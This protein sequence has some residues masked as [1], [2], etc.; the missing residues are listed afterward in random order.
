M[1]SDE[2]N[3][4]RDKERAIKEINILLKSEDEIVR[5][6][7]QD[8]KQTTQEHRIS[9]GY[10][11]QMVES[12]KDQARLTNAEQ[13]SLEALT[14][15]YQDIAKYEDE[16]VDALK[17]RQDQYKQ[18]TDIV[19][20][21]SSFEKISSAGLEQFK[22]QAI[23]NT[24][25]W[26]I[27]SK[28]A[29]VKQ[30]Q[31][32]ES[33]SARTPE[34]KTFDDTITRAKLIA[35]QQLAQQISQLQQDTDNENALNSAKFYEAKGNF[36][37]AAGER[38]KVSINE[39]V[40]TFTEALSKMQAYDASITDKQV[41]KSI[42]AFTERKK[43]AVDYFG[44]IAALQLAG[45]PAAAKQLSLEAQ[46]KEEGEK[47]VGEK[48]AG[49]IAPSAKKQKEEVDEY[50]TKKKGSTEYLDVKRKAAIESG[51]IPGAL[52]VGAAQMGKETVDAIKN[53]GTHFA[54]L[55]TSVMTMAGVAA[56][57]MKIVA[58][59]D[60]LRAEGATT[61]KIYTSM[62]VATKELTNSTIGSIK[63]AV[64]FRNILDYTSETG[65]KDIDFV[66]TMTIR[67]AGLEKFV[68]LVGQAY[69]QTA[70]SGR[71][72]L[73]TNKQ[74][75]GENIQ[76]IRDTALLG[77]VF[78]SSA[79]AGMQFA[80]DVFQNLRKSGQD[81]PNLY[82]RIANA[83]M[84]AGMGFS[85][86]Y[87]MI[88]QYLPTMYESGVGTSELVNTFGNFS[89]TLAKAGAPITFIQN[90]LSEMMKLT[91]TNFPQMIAETMAATGSTAT[92]ALAEI[93]T[94]LGSTG[95]G[96]MLSYRLQTERD[97][98]K[99]FGMEPKEG[100]FDLKS[101]L[102]LQ[103]QFGAS[104]QAILK[105]QD[106][107]ANFLGPE[108]GSATNKDLTDLTQQIATY[109]DLGLKTMIDQKT[110]LELIAD[111]IQNIVSLIAEYFV[112]L[113]FNTAELNTSRQAKS[114]ESQSLLSAQS[115][116]GTP[117]ANDKF[118]INSLTGMNF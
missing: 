111:G 27:K 40:Q 71:L 14:K 94:K 1:A 18:F 115:Q 109:D 75:H 85:E 81:I 58:A 11:K 46:Y 25:S 50:I 65:K 91:Q 77:Q 48:Y 113:G 44:A 22:K 53:I 12:L 54:T 19:A 3:L 76:S 83:A 47:L 117:V 97:I 41:K 99:K 32:I 8:L 93:T 37:K 26:N 103:Q 101:L 35:E 42:D 118:S 38:A 16:S 66:N 69:N 30:L 13:A 116:S 59:L 107:F 88:Q 102:F 49:K 63:Q 28:I 52:K 87:K 112:R 98:L 15:I 105:Y 78:Q 7:A 114:M 62:G 61:T 90:R 82:M 10:T 17:R 67:Q 96:N 20:K 51:N 29:E 24:I 79:D 106:Q 43:A 100:K 5:R 68:A 21:L 60:A 108:G 72:L 86:F 89:A 74:L 84:N 110:T 45:K 56:I 2:I 33:Q 39:E 31:D 73:E 64:N 95:E 36:A 70:F 57:I 34:S 6:V 80:V 9:L 55:I 23:T 104:P 92:A 4:Q